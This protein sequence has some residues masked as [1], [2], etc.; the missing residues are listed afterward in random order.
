MSPDR[1]VPW[2]NGP[3]GGALFC[4]GGLAAY[5]AALYSPAT[6]PPAVLPL[7]LTIMGELIP[8]PGYGL[9]WAVCWALCWVAAFA[10]RRTA[11]RDHADRWAFGLL[12]F[13]L[14]V[15]GI[16]YLGGWALYLWG[17][18][19]ASG[20]HQSWFEGGRYVCTA[21]AICAA[22]R[23]SNPTRATRDAGV[24]RGGRRR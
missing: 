12:V 6:Q 13:L 8:I 19:E 1:L 18:P 22:T 2:L 7:G 10:P 14:T 4:L 11:A 24:R 20:S 16:A 15:W 17:I 5:H 21:A 3:R 23:M 9:L